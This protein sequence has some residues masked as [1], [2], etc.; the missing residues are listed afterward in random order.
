MHHSILIQFALAVDPEKVKQL[1]DIIN[2]SRQEMEMIEE[3]RIPVKKQ[4]DDLAAKEKEI[5]TRWVGVFL[6]ML[7]QNLTFIPY[8]EELKRVMDRVKAESTR[9]QRA[10]AQLGLSHCVILLRDLTDY[11]A[12]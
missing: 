8:Q 4:L 11:V 3:E 12:L 6:S 9:V 7:L 5:Q 1:K 2:E 10:R